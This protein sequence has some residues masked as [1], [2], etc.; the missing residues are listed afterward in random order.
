M[1]RRHLIRAALGVSFIGALLIAPVAHGDGPLPGLC[2]INPALDALLG[3]A[4]A[5]PHQTTTTTPTTTAA[6][7]TPPKAPTPPPQHEAVVRSST[8]ATY[9]PNVLVVRI[10]HGVSH[11]RAAALLSRLHVRTREAIGPLGIRVVSVPPA[12]RAQVLAALDRSRLVAHATRDELVHVLGGFPNDPYFSYQWGFRLAG[13]STLWQSTQGPRSVLV[14]VVDTGV[15]FG[16]PDLAG[17]VR[18]GVDLVNP[19]GTGSDDNG[20]GTAVAAVIAALANNGV[21]AAGVCGRCS[22]LPIKVM[23]KN[24]NGDLGTV[25]A[26]IVRAADMGARV[27]DL[28][29]GGPAGQDALQQAIAYAN[30]KGAL[31]VAA[32]GN[33]GRTTTF[34]PAGYPNVLS[35]AGSNPQDRLYSWSEHGPWVHVTA[36]GCN[37]APLLSGGYGTFCG[38]SSATPVVAGL[39]GVLLSA[40][41]Q[42]T[43]AQLIRLIQSTARRIKTGAQFGRIRAVSALAAA[44][45]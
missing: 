16:Q 22:I 36:P 27:I 40:N 28:S 15:D 12:R 38:T 26:G 23:G 6:A 35:V 32:A 43:N 8:H 19:G 20:H 9:L 21:G 11:A 30:S 18:P 1:L 29:L 5:P 45:P 2:G 10:R 14:A 39:A 44:R 34:Y 41:P 42:L 37:V 7:P 33:S 13:F 24:G 25:A 4:S 17:A 3:C 31:V